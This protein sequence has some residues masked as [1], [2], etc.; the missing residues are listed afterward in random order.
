MPDNPKPVDPIASPKT[1]RDSRDPSGF[2]EPD[3]PDNAADQIV[4]ESNA[5]KGGHDSRDEASGFDE[6]KPSDVHKY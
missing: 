4:P 1:K 3:Y 6:R 5:V 2:N